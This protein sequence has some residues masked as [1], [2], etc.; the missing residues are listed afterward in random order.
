MGT[1]PVQNG[2]YRFIPDLFFLYRIRNS[3]DQF[4]VLSVLRELLALGTVDIG[5]CCRRG[6]LRGDLALYLRK[7][8]ILLCLKFLLYILSICEDL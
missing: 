6:S 8:R 3:Y 2:I 4:P 5:P 1:D 7:S